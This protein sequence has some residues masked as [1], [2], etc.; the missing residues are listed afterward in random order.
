MS[1]AIGKLN[2][3]YWIIRRPRNEWLWVL[4][5]EFIPPNKTPQGI[6]MIAHEFN[7]LFDVDGNNKHYKV[8]AKKL[9]ETE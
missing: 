4:A 6:S 7:E 2:K 3:K 9:Y 5:I 8:P 1:E